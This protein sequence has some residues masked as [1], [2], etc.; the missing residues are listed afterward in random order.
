MQCYLPMLWERL[1]VDIVVVVV[2][3]ISSP[4]G[5]GEIDG[6]YGSTDRKFQA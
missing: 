4:P 3:A 5:C 2:V 1:D 6:N